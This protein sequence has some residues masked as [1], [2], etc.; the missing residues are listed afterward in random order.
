[1]AVEREGDLDLFAIP[2]LDAKGICAPANIRSYRLN[3]AVMCA[4]RAACV[5]LQDESVLA[6][7]PVHSLGIDWLLS[8]PSQ[9]GGDPSIT[10]GWSTLKKRTLGLNRVVDLIPDSRVALYP[11][12]RELGCYI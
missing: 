1:M 12:N 7:D 2:A 11:I 3:F 9:Q 8:L 6:H 10:I 5:P 4:H